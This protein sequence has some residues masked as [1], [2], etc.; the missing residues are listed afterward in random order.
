MQ[1]RF[2]RL[3]EDELR[4]V[5]AGTSYVEQLQEK[6]AWHRERIFGHKS[7]ATGT[8]TDRTAAS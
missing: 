5:A 2:P 6:I 8:P 7:A 1:D 3:T 4:A